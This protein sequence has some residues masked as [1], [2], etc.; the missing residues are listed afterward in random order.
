MVSILGEEGWRRHA[1]PWSVYTRFA[2]IPAGILAGWS[3]VWIEGWAILPLGLV[4]LWL[5]INPFVFK[6]VRNPTHWIS[7]GILGEQ[8]WLEKNPA[9]APHHDM[10]RI[11]LVFGIVGMISMFS[12]VFWL[13]PWA[14]IAGAVLVTV[15]QIWRIRRFA[16]AFDEQ[17]AS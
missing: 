11:L 3:R 16:R 2:A 10:L 6:P 9:L 1:N 8:L 15:T 4:V 7:K 5:V 13:N 12:G 14:A 17:A